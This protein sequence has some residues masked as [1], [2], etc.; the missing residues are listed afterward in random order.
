MIL[1]QMI[2]DKTE[3]LTEKNKQ[4][5]NQNNELIAINEEIK[6]HNRRKGDI[7]AFIRSIFMLFNEVAHQNKI[8][9]TI[10]ASSATLNTCFYHEKMERII[11]N[12]LSNAFKSTNE[13]GKI[14]IAIEQ[15]TGNIQIDV[16]DTGSG[17]P[18]SETETIFEPFSHINN[19]SN[20][21]SSRIN[22]R[23]VKR[24]VELHKG[25]IEVSSRLEM[26]SKF[27]II[28]P[29]VTNCPPAHRNVESPQLL[30]NEDSEVMLADFNQFS[31][32]MFK[33]R[34]IDNNF[35]LPQMVI[36][37]PDND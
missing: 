8:A 5:E 9:F 29:I 18:T 19:T 13:G 28:I 10:E 30:I 33:D 25:T 2:I 3:N 34:N 27:T 7:I 24:Y 26:G 6:N 32:M 20:P 17:L 22:L 11:Y 14:S 21:A 15:R 37:E 31:K 1:K 23:V 4:I 35:T 16:T 12:L 36:V